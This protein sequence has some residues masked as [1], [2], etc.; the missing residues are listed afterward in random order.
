MCTGPRENFFPDKFSLSAERQECFR[1]RKREHVQLLKMKEEETSQKYE[2]RKTSL[3]FLI[4]S[5]QARLT[6]LPKPN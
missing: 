3:F 4:V 1:M 5:V 2:L 6:N